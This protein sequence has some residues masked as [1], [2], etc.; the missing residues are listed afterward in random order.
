M[1]KKEREITD[2]KEREAVLVRAQVMRLAINEAGA[3]PYIVPVN[4]GYRD[5]ALY[6]HSSY[7]G[8]K[9][10]L[11]TKDPLV[12]FEAEADVAIVAPA[13]RSN[14]CE[15]GVAYRSVIGRGRA[16]ILTNP[17]EKRTGLRVLMASVAPD[18]DPSS[19]TM[20]DQI[21]AITAVVRIDI[22]SMTGK[23]YRV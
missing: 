23:K 6:F 12:A 4:F 11:I 19:F 8:K 16:T 21:V 14:A 3:P 10:E 22:E 18:V 1:R 15:W 9:I 17:E 20:A 5:N 13:D 7:E 2:R